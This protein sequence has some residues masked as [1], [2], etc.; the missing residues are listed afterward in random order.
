MTLKHYPV[1]TSHEHID[2]SLLPDAKLLP[3]GEK[4]ID[5]IHLTIP[6]FNEVLSFVV[7]N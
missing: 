1:I 4:H 3:S 2:L 7:L 6:A 5:Y